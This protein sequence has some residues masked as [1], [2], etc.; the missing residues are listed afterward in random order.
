LTDATEQ[1]RRFEASVDEQHVDEALLAAMNSGLPECAGVAVGLER[2]HM[3][4]DQTD[5]IRNVITFGAISP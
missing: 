3:V 1:R 5:D 4:L 2:L